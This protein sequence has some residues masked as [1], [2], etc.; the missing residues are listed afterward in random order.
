MPARESRRVRT[1]PLTVTGA[2]FVT[3][4]IAALE[5]GLLKTAYSASIPA[6][7]RSVRYS[8]LI[9]PPNQRG[10][11]EAVAPKLARCHSTL[12]TTPHRPPALEVLMMPSRAGPACR[13]CATVGFLA[14][15]ERCQHSTMY[16]GVHAR[17]GLASLWLGDRCA[18]V[19]K[20]TV[21]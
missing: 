8:S 5:T 6:P 1:Q 17:V 20:M 3:L 10:C 9:G 15:A 13:R 18:D 21:F 2:S 12:A 4:F 7:R 14:T 16:Q 19:P 11:E